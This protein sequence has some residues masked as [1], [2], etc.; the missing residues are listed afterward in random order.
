MT[1]ARA[2]QILKKHGIFN[3]KGSNRASASFLLGAL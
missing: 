2:I 3:E 1:Y